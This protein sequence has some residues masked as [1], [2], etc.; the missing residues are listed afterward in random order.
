[1]IAFTLS[2]FAE[3]IDCDAGSAIAT[4]EYVMSGATVSVGDT[5][6][7][8]DPVGCNLV[9]S[10]YLLLGKRGWAAPLVGLSCTS[11]DPYQDDL[12]SFAII[13]LCPSDFSCGS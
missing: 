2:E 8:C 3:D 6:V 11:P 7:V 5:I 10:E 13:T 1:M 4:V 9:G 12:P